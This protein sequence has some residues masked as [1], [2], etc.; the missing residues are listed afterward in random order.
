MKFAEILKQYP[1]L[2]PL[3]ANMPEELREHFRLAQ[4]KANGFIHEKNTQLDAFGILCKGECRIINILA[5][6]N[7]YMIER[8]K[9]VA[10]IG[11]VTLMAGETLSSVSIETVTPCDVL[12]LP[13]P[14]FYSWIQRDIG[15][16][17][18]L[19]QQIARKLYTTSSAQGER[20]YYPVQYVVLSY[21]LKAW[22]GD[23]H[24]KKQ[25]V[26]GETRQQMC[27]S[28][29]LTVKTLNRTISAF[30]DSGLVSIQ[31]GKVSFT[32]TQVEQMKKEAQVYVG[33]NRRS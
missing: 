24:K 14:D 5:N 6:G 9:A 33:K 20:Q 12:Y 17:Y 15:F 31:K 13:L 25:F 4:Y 27:E 7:V 10:F 22:E 11:E 3:L 18:H 1:D 19:N 32:A 26:L 21:L 2:K 30:R 28:M 23:S 16:L 29:G 8:N